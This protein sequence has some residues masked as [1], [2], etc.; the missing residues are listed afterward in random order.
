MKTIPVK[1]GKPYE[2]L[3]ENGL[4]DRAG[5]LLLSALDKPGKLAILTDDTV[6][7]LYGSRVQQSMEKAGFQVCRYGIPHGEGSKNLTEWGKMLSFL[8]QHHLTRTDC[9]LALGGGVPG[10][11]AGFAAA[12]YLR[13]IA[14]A[15]MPTTLLAMVDSSVGGKTGVNLPEG[16]NLVGAFYQPRIVLCDPETLKTLPRETLLDG[17]AESVKYG[18]LGDLP[19]FELFERGQWENEVEM[20]LERCIAAKA[21]LVEEDER[22]TGSRQLLNLGH[23]LGHAI[24][25]C[26][27]YSISHG[28]AVAVGMVYAARLSWRRGLC[29]ESVLVRMTE[30]LQRL[31]LPVSAPFSADELLAVALSDK[32]RAGDSITFVLPQE[33]GKCTLSQTAIANLPDMVRMAIG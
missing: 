1:A 27:G 17:V 24:E 21:K 14:F 28:H 29:G 3:V 31:G 19:L 10:D 32:K 2:V 23:T 5:E 12:S 25:K 4:M 9:V 16:K 20:I 13:G 18:V 7:G 11:M 26:S 30:T 8:A 22:D 6:D 15:Q 33:I